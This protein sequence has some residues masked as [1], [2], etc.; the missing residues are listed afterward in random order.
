V[1]LAKIFRDIHTIADGESYDWGRLWGSVGAASYLGL[2]LW[3][4]VVRNDP[5]DATTWAMGLSTVL[6]GVG[7]TL[8]AK[9]NTEPK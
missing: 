6:V 4:Y 8:L 9:N 2:S 7:L 3:R 5:W 1:I